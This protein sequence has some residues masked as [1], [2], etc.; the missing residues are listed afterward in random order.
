MG[1]AGMGCAGMGGAGWVVRGWV[2]RVELCI[3][4]NHKSYC[5]V[6]YSAVVMES[7]TPT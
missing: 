3:G 5:C 1:G 7:T 4:N 6:L 2:V